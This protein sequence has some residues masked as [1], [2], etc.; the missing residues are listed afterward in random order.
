MANYLAGL[1]PAVASGG[2]GHGA[3][4]SPAQYAATFMHLWWLGLVIGAGYF[5][6][7][8]L[9]NRLMHGVK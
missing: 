5:L 9:I 4:S 1:I 6:C 2:G 7:A 8:P 3:A